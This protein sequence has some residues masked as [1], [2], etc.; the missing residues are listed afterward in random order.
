MTLNRVPTSVATKL[1]R[2]IDSITQ[3]LSTAPAVT[4]V[5]SVPALKHTTTI[6]TT[7]LSTAV[8]IVSPKPSETTQQTLPSS[9]ASSSLQSLA[10][11]QQTPSPTHVQSTGTTATQILG[12]TG[13]TA[14]QILGLTT[15]SPSGITQ[16]R[17]P[18]PNV[19]TTHSHGS[20]SLPSAA[21]R[22]QITLSRPTTSI[23]SLVAKITLQINASKL[24]TTT[25]LGHTE[26][27]STA[28]PSVDGSTLLPTDY[29]TVRVPTEQSLYNTSTSDRN[30]TAVARSH[31]TITIYVSGGAAATVCVILAVAVLIL[32]VW[33]RRKHLQSHL[34]GRVHLLY[35]YD[36][37][38]D[39]GSF[40]FCCQFQTDP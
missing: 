30:V 29:S 32:V 12:L 22:Q 37:F 10:T 4:S 11:L 39:A 7:E 35:K 9:R 34:A 18:S 20:T 31:A 38:V 25:T 15:S 8:A 28:S 13:T 6:A 33:R 21:A 5:L 40:E 19:T 24:T 1:L 26:P 17:T 23:A 27:L 36:S 14:T 16:Q 3:K 2:S